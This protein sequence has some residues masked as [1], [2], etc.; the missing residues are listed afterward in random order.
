LFE[1]SLLKFISKKSK[2]KNFESAE[3]PVVVVDSDNN[4][5]GDRDIF[6]LEEKIEIGKR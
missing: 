2:G 1:K 3:E 4:M 6:T 5:W